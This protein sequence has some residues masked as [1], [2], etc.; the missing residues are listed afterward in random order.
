ML[1]TKLHWNDAVADGG[2]GARRP[3]WT[4]KMERTRRREEENVTD[5][6]G[7]AGW[8]RTDWIAVTRRRGHMLDCMED[9]RAGGST[10]LV[11]LRERHIVVRRYCMA[12]VDGLEE[13][14]LHKQMDYKWEGRRPRAEE[15]SC[16]L[17][18]RISPQDGMGVW[19]KRVELQSRPDYKTGPRATEAFGDEVAVG[20]G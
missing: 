15:C 18:R 3:R 7:S 6:A 19:R 1:G 8:E 12:A 10:A 14:R 17:E 16:W 11:V 4:Q 2:A 9:W 13:R 20:T 5:T